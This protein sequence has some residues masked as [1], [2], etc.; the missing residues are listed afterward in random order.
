MNPKIY[1]AQIASVC[2]R[3]F[4]AVKPKREYGEIEIDPYFG[5]ATPSKIILRGR[6]L[7]RRA[8]KA[9]EELEDDPNLWTNFKSMIALFNTREISDVL[10]CCGDIETYS[11][12]EGY[13]EIALPRKEGGAGWSTYEISFC[14]N[15]SRAELTALISSPAAKFGIISD[16]D[17]TLIKTD[18]WSLRRNLWNSLTGN[19]QTRHVYPDAIELISKLHADENPVFYVSSSPW[20]MHGFLTEIFDRAGLVRGPKFLRDLGISDTKFI[21]GTQKN[22]KADAI[23]SILTA[24]PD[25]PFVLLGDTGQHDAHVYHDAILRHPG[26]IQQIILRA[27]KPNLSKSNQ[28]WVDKIKATDTPL[29]IGGTYERLL[30]T[31]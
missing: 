4:D 6:V 27:P 31:L 16:I 7:T 19:A 2:E 25:L 17:D 14:E 12:E 23:D 10:I 5:H 21:T 8:I 20:N 3:V 30:K 26:R 11:D 18:A 28:I 24:N 9:V 29:F 1:L 15:E 22:H 13:F